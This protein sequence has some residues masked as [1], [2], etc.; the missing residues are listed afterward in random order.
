M[1]KTIHRMIINHSDRLHVGIDH[2]GPQEFESPF[3]QVLGPDFRLRDHDR[4]I[5]NPSK[6]MENGFVFHPTPHVVGKTAEFLLDFHEKPGI[7]DSSRDLRPVPHDPGV[8][9]QAGPIPGLEPGDVLV[10]KTLEG[11][12]EVLPLMKDGPPGKTGLE[13]FQ[14]EEFEYFSIFADGNTPL[15]IVIGKHQGIIMTR[16]GASDNRFGDGFLDSFFQSRTFW[17]L[18]SRGIEMELCDKAILSP[19]SLQHGHSWLFSSGSNR[20]R[21]PP[22]LHAHWSHP[23]NNFGYRLIG[24]LF[25]PK[26]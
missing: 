8:L 23:R 10:I 12:S 7:F 15:S 17:N 18:P 13:G 19:V 24:G 16:P 21:W 3:F 20:R 11:F 6:P 25:C 26:F 14:N 1:A 9:H 2:S 5:F 22:Y 4:V